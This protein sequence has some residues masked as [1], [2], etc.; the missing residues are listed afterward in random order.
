MM[1]NA[2]PVLDEPRI[3]RTKH[4]GR[5]TGALLCATLAGSFSS[6]P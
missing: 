1:G 2:A 6:P 4:I 5:W 3:V